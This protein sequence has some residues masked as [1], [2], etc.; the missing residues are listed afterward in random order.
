MDLRVIF[1]GA[2]SQVSA[3]IEYLSLSVGFPIFH[4][5]HIDFPV[6][7]NHCHHFDETDS[8]IR[9]VAAGGWPNGTD[10]VASPYRL[11]PVT[12]ARHA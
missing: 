9:M 10:S 2:Y 12:K 3:M 6:L 7:S 11:R 8:P 5:F 1:N 4:V